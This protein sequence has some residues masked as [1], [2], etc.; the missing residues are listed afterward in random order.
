MTGAKKQTDNRSALW[1]A[2]A[3]LAFCLNAV[4]P[5]PG[6]AA[7]VLPPDVEATLRQAADAKPEA[8]EEEGPW[9]G[10]VVLGA[11]VRTGDTDNAGTTAEATVAYAGGPWLHKGEAGLDSLRNRTLGVRF[12]N[13]LSWELS[14]TAKLDN[15]TE[16]LADQERVRV[17][18]HRQA[19][20]PLGQY[21]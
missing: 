10:T 16:A 17:N 13:L 7:T 12:T 14:D 2:V 3:P 8:I 19:K 5:M 6:T 9:N 11:T 21:G 15:E 18:S 20:S 4:A 1:L